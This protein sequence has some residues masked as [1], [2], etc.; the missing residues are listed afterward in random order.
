[1]PISTTETE[2]IPGSS[3]C[4]KRSSGSRASQHPTWKL[5]NEAG[6]R[7]DNYAGDRTTSTSDGELFS[8]SFDIMEPPG[9]TVLSV[10]RPKKH[11][12]LAGL[13]P[14]VLAADGNAVLLKMT[15][16]ATNRSPY[17]EDYFVYKACTSDGSRRPSLSRDT[18]SFDG[19]PEPHIFLTTKAIGIL[20]CTEESF[21]VAELQKTALTSEF[22]VNVQISGSDEWTVFDRL[23]VRR[24]SG[25]HDMVWWTTN[26]VVPYRRRFLIWVDYHRGMIVADMSSCSENNKKPAPPE[27]R[28]VLLP[29][30]MTDENPE[31]PEYG[32]GCPQ[33]SRSVCATHSGIK[34]V[35]VDQ[36]E[37]SSFGAGKLKRWRNTLRITT[38]SLRDDDYRWR[39]EAK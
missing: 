20:S 3:R 6:G 34:F 27:L 7:R 18:I 32:R 4:S 28:F 24:A 14:Q 12:S 21:V 25:R 33:A 31:D 30:D 13:Q 5:L 17:L 35:S 16:I 38:W 2:E 19:L 11:S 26:A 36:K 22:K 10:D 29:V 23:P 9:T 1:M 8:V 15:P 39:R 37:T